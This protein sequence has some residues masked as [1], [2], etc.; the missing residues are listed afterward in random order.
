[1]AA[2]SAL[3]VLMFV[4]DVPSAIA[5]TSEEQAKDFLSKDAMLQAAATIMGLAIFGSAIGMRIHRRP[6]HKDA[7]WKGGIIAFIGIICLVTMQVVFMVYACCESVVDAWIQVW[8]V[9][10][11]IFLIVI[12]S[13]VTV[14]LS[15][16]SKESKEALA[17]TDGCASERSGVSTG[18][19]D[20]SKETS[21][22]TDT[23][24]DSRQKGHTPKSKFS[25][26]WPILAFVG[27]FFGMPAAFLIPVHGFD[28]SD[29]TIVNLAND[30]LSV[31]GLGIGSTVGIFI[32][33]YALGKLT[34]HAIDVLN[35][36]L[37]STRLHIIIIIGCTAALAYLLI[38]IMHHL[39]DEYANV[40]LPIAIGATVTVFISLVI[41][42]I[43]MWHDKETK[44]MLKG[45][46]E[47]LKEISKKLD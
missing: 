33:K 27:L 20:R 43:T 6:K 41:L 23:R 8:I 40:L 42:L 39:P 30:M 14:A 10:T 24:L 11:A 38:N 32:L 9:L 36:L 3:V 2:S 12:G 44:L 45:I 28:I 18:P 46:N 22:T 7:R 34:P 25:R 21:T 1:M 5:D 16:S 26:V 4:I 15:R 31:L 47:T 29:P 17:T 35:W 19:D 37:S 13:G